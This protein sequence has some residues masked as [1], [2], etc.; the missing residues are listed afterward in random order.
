MALTGTFG[1]G[2]RKQ[3][4][5]QTLPSNFQQF[6]KVD[7]KGLK[8]VLEYYV[9]STLESKTCQILRQPALRWTASA[10][11]VETS[12]VVETGHNLI[13]KFTLSEDIKTLLVTF[14]HL[15]DSSKRWK[16]PNLPKN[17]MFAKYNVEVLTLQKIDCMYHFSNFS[18]K[19]SDKYPSNRFNKTHTTD[20][21]K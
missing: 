5:H 9:T 11:I 2:V 3:Q 14:S 20:S 21:W 8:K 7:D 15:C 16:I 4:I 1:I 17:M 19:P 6:D 10:V 12:G 13:K 18:K